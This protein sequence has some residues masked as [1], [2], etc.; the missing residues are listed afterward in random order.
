MSGGSWQV[1]LSI[2]CS[3][4]RMGPASNVV[5]SEEPRS[6]G[7]YHEAITYQTMAGTAPV[8]LP[9]G[10]PADCFHWLR[11]YLPSQGLQARLTGPPVGPRV[12]GLPDGN[13]LE[14]PLTLGSQEV[15]NYLSE[16]PGPRSVV[17]PEP[18]RRPAMCTG[19]GRQQK[20][21]VKIYLG[22]AGQKECRSMCRGA[23]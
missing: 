3:S 1:Y 23:T 14:S 6:R 16:P 19:S 8:A 22:W 4:S 10:C 5:Y 17:S 11:R 20:V 13:P 15:E 12:P 21:T 2:H 9:P 7:N 18:S